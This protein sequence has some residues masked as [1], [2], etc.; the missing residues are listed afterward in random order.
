MEQRSRGISHG[1]FSAMEN[2]KEERVANTPPTINSH[3]QMAILPS[4]PI[5]KMEDLNR[6]QSANQIC[7]KLGKQKKVSTFYNEC[8]SS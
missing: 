7:L 4:S 5:K 2:I 1:D 6:G 3:R 8:D